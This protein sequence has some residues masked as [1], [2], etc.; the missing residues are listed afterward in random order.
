M[1]PA[2]KGLESAESTDHP[3]EWSQ[4]FPG[5]RRAVPVWAGVLPSANG[6]FISV[7]YKAPVCDIP[8]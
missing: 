8:L 5:I 6:C 2:G 7:F 4:D 3:G 1:G